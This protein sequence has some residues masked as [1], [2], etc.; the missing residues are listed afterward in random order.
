MLNAIGI[1]T[2][3]ISGW[4]FDK[5]VISGNKNTI[6]HAWTAAYIND[7]WIEL[8]ATWGLFEGI[9]AGHILKNF[10]KE[11]FSFQGMNQVTLSKDP[12]I[13]LVD[14]LDI[15]DDEI[16]NDLDIKHDMETKNEENPDEKGD[17]KSNEKNNESNG[18]NKNFN[19]ESGSGNTDN[20]NGSIKT[21]ISRLIL[22]IYLL[23]LLL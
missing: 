3:Y 6:G 2:L 20:D 7:K 4:A 13:Q 19:E 21:D 5:N 1:K 8:D 12:T 22:I 11:S 14:N 10:D 23:N 15:S 16:I 18:N 17:E 9:P